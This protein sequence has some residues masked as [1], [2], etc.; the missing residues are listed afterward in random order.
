MLRRENCCHPEPCR[1]KKIE[2]TAA[3][4]IDAGLVGDKTD[5]AVSNQVDAVCQQDFDSRAYPRRH[6][7]R[8]AAGR[9]A[10]ARH[11]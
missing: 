8:A 4:R 11:P 9:A 10:Q 5:A 6:Y 1:E 3:A 7:A 2:I